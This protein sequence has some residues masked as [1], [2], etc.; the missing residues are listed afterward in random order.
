[1]DW[2]D[3]RDKKPDPEK[4]QGWYVVLL[5]WCKKPHIVYFAFRNWK[6]A[7]HMPDEWKD[8]EFYIKL[9]SIP[10]KWN[11]SESGSW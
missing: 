8:P 9:D 7:W 6:S 4:D 5:P 3:V 11:S 1:M 10:E 2:V